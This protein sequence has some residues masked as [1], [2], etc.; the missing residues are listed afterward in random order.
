M[1]AK[2]IANACK[3]S[4][5]YVKGPEILNKYFGESE[6]SIRDLFERARQNSPCLIFFDEIDGLCPRRSS[7]GNQ[8]IERVVNQLLTELNGLDNKEGLFFIGA[9]NRPDIIDTAVLRPERLGL[10]LYVPLPSREDRVEIL[11]T[12]L[13]QKPVNREI[14]GEWLESRFDLRNFLGSRPQQHRTERCQRGRLGRLQR[15]ETRGSAF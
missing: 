11:S 6:K 15:R 8:V 3:A 5:I 2:A 10:H 13:K 1:L 7:E 9:T 12:I 4:F 14:T